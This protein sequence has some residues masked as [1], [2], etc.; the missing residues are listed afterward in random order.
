M[1]GVQTCALPICYNG[2]HSSKRRTVRLERLDPSPSYGLL[3]APCEQN[4]VSRA[5]DKRSGGVWPLMYRAE[6]TLVCSRNK[7]I[8]VSRLYYSLCSALELGKRL[9]PK[10]F[11]QS[12]Y[13]LQLIEAEAK[14]NPSIDTSDELSALPKR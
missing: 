11:S 1:T 13:Q 4:D 2:A 9:R 7:C 8:Q 12:R 6:G 10:Y 3:E 5:I 14:C